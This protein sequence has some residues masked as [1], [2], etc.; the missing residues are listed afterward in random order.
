MRLNSEKLNKEFNDILEDVTK[1]E[2]EKRFSQTKA[3]KRGA[4]KGRFRLFM[5][6]SHEDFIG[7]L[8][9]FIGKGEVGNKQ[10]KWFEDNLISPLN[11]AYIELN[12]AK[13]AI[14]NDYKQLMKNSGDIKKKLKSKLPDGDFTYEDAVR[15]YLWDKHGLDI[16]G[17]SPTDQKKLVEAVMMDQKLRMFAEVLNFISRQKE[18][19]TPY[20][21]WEGG[22]IK[23]DLNE[24]MGET[25]RKKYFAEFLEKAGVIFSEEN[26][27]KIEAAY[28]PRLREALEDMLYRIETGRNR[29]QG[30][31]RM[32]NKFMNWLNGSVASVMFLNMRSALLQQ[33]SIV[34]FLKERRKGIGTDINGNDLARSLQ[35][36]RNPMAKLLQILLRAGFT[37]TQVAD[38]IAIA[39]GGATFYRNRIKTYLKEGL[40]QKEAES[41]AF[42]DFQEIAEETQQSAREDKVS[43]QQ[44]SWVGK[45]ILNFQNVTSQYNRIGKRSFLDLKNRR[46]SKGYKTQRASDLANIS[47]IAYYLAVQNL[48]FYGLQS[49]IFAAMFD[50]EEEGLS[51]KERKERKKVLDKKSERIINGSID[52]VLRGSGMFGAIISVLKNMA[53]KFQDERNKDYNHDESAVLMEALNVSPV[54]GI[55]ARKIVIAEKTMNYDKD[56][57]NYMDTWDIDNPAWQANFAYTEAVTNAPLAKTYN[58]IQNVRDAIQLETTMLNRILMFFGYSKYN[59]GVEEN[60]E[61]QMLEKQAKEAKKSKK[62]KKKTKLLPEF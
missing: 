21:G 13:Q 23:T 17:L 52:S 6:P 16:P 53:I 51:E 40:S 57:I 5:P 9:N 44:A 19:I 29:P 35:D 32:L 45:V 46:I 28:G 41:K 43:M 54:V 31:N 20:N 61:M 59:L 10:R 38:N 30:Q 42:E 34:N 7:L 11:R 36:S 26:L 50:E 37:P 58:K 15:V 60:I 22:S 14:A 39:T 48:I 56:L 24:A 27:N 4:K 55:K 47:R 8:Y 3:R 2:S 1:I 49:A 33:M 18:Y 62:K 12:A 25:G